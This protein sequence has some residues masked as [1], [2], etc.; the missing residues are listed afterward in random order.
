MVTNNAMSTC[1]AVRVVGTYFTMKERYVFMI[2][3]VF[4]SLQSSSNDTLLNC[5]V[6]NRKVPP[7]INDEERQAASVDD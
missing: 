5:I 1:N 4:T 7:I 2:A 3:P 6:E